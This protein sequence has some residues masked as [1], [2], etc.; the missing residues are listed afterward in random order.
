MAAL[1]LPEDL[2]K[3]YYKNGKIFLIRRVWIVPPRRAAWTESARPRAQQHTPGLS[4]EMFFSP[5]RFMA[6]C[7]RGRALSGGAVS[8][9]ADFPEAI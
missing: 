2:R 4:A 7:A 1:S 9:A 6:C 3:S 8:L 5:L